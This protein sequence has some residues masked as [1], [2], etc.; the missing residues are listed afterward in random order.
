MAIFTRPTLGPDR[1]EARRA[2]GSV[3]SWT[4]P[5]YGGSLPHDLVHVMVEAGFELRRG[6]WGLVEG[7][8][9]PALAN[10]RVR[11]GMSQSTSS[12]FAPEQTELL[13]SEALCLMHWYDPD[14]TG[15]ARCEQIAAACAELRVSRPAALTPE[16]ANRVC[17]LARALRRRWRALGDRPRLSLDF[18]PEDATG[19]F[20][21]LERFGGEP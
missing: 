15:E 14:P 2:D 9:D 21:R 5:T 10:Q 6:L 18:S 16:R 13:Q 1:V 17:V 20:D 7:G 11:D 3:A 4:C 8:L 12:R 19:T